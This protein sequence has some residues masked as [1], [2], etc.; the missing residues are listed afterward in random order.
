MVTS[1]TTIELLISLAKS[2]K[3]P[4]ILSPDGQLILQKL[5]TIFEE[6]NH[7]NMSVQKCHQSGCMVY[8]PCTGKY[9]KW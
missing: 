3:D 6:K 9:H 4:T 2:I 5:N 1:E 8:S 7:S